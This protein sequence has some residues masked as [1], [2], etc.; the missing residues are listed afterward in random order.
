MSQCNFRKLDGTKCRLKTHN[1]F[2][3]MHSKECSICYEKLYSEKSIK[4]SCG[5]EFHKSCLTDWF[6]RDNKCPLC[7]EETQHHDFKVA[8]SDN[9][10]LVRMDVASLLDKLQEIEVRGVFKG[11]KLAIDVLDKK[12]AG[13]FNFHTKELL[14]TFKIN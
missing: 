8:V 12:T 1:D 7:R 14:G 3:Y 6:E 4:T 5:H 10:L 11:N 13:V 2:C 9:P